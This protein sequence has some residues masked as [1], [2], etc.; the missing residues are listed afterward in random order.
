MSELQRREEEIFA[1]A[2]ARPTGDRQR[3]VAEA[4]A[5]DDALLG[6]IEALL[7]ADESARQF[8]AG[9]SAYAAKHDGEVGPPPAMTEAESTVIGHY[10]LL[11]KLGE[12]GCGVVWMAEQEVPVRRRVALKIIKL[13]MDTKLVIARFEAER[14]AL[15]MMDH[16]NIAKIFDAG[17]TESGRPY[18]VMEL[19]RGV[20]ITEFCDQFNQSTAQ[21]LELFSQVCGAV[22][23]AHQKGIIH[24]DLK[25]SNILVALYDGVPVPKVID[26]GI[27]K[28]SEGRLTDSTLFTALEQFIGTPAYMSPEQAELGGMDIDTRSDIYSL[29]V[30]LYELL[31]GRPPFDPKTLVQAGLDEIRRIIREVEPPRP[32]TNLS[33][34]TDADLTKI[35]RHRGTDPTRLSLQLRGDLDWI[36]MRC[37]EKNRMRRYQT[38]NALAADIARHLHHEPVIARPPSGAYRFGRLVRRNRLLFTAIATVALALVAGTAI[39]LW[40]AVRARQAERQAQVERVRAEDLLK[41]MLGDLYTQLDKVGRLDV[42]DAVADKAT[43]YFASLGPGELDDTSRLS[44]ARALR[45]LGGVRMAQARYEDAIAAFTGAYQRSADLAAHAPKDTEVLYERDQTEYWLGIVHQKRAEYAAAIDWMTRYRETS[46]MLVA[47]E[48]SKPEWRLELLDGYNNLAAVRE[49]Q[50]DLASAKTEFDAELAALGPMSASDPTNL[51]LRKREVSAHFNLGQIADQR[52]EFAEALKQYS[53]Q[54]AELESVARADPASAESRLD[55]GRALLYVTKIDIATGHFAAAS[56]EQKRAQTLL[57]DLV[58]RDGTNVDWR[59]ADLIARLAKVTLAR[60]RAEIGEASREL[61]RDLPIIEAMAAN[62]PSDPFYAALLMHGWRLNAQVQSS[63]GEPEAAN[64]ASHAIEIGERLSHGEGTDPADI[65]EC[66]R[67]YVVR[68][69][70]SAKAGNGPAA[71]R[72]WQRAAELVA[73]LAGGINYQ[74]LDPAVRAAAWLGHAQESRALIEKLTLLGY[75]PVDPWPAPDRPA[76]AKNSEPQPK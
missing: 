17:A 9:V 5:G 53:T 24:R 45:L 2:L 30:L 69:E 73:P 8:L 14:Q 10:K 34:L 21:R 70:I 72:D 55:E 75:V 46:R 20:R 4:C 48:P 60:Q 1:K 12:G 31:V 33:T 23:H 29:G 51:E 67:S 54:A 19:V 42:L 44:R 32:S 39:S 37:L 13:G 56:D 61:A 50:G 64:S 65:A 59:S 36:V 27:A 49:D 68:G 57:D 71:Q 26:F 76:L 66:A 15:A 43:A 7:R 41:F 6:R 40:Q 74:V 62:T 58:A 16:P 28:A 63:A 38:P 25:P 22:Q 18:F 11:Q 47:L 3:F 35:A 52:G